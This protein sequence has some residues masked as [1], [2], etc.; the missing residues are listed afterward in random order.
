MSLAC[1]RANCHCEA[2]FLGARANVAY[3]FA[4]DRF[5]RQSEVQGW[6]ERVWGFL[7]R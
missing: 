3:Y 5:E 6:S 4:R 7:W 2:Q 1:W